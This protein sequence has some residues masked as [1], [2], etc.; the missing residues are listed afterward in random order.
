MAK[1]M[2]LTNLVVE[3]DNSLAIK[4]CISENVPPWDN[5][6]IFSDIKWLSQARNMTFSW[7]RRIHNRLVHWIA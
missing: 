2:N 4:L 6:A 5:K 3:S 7:T 1:E